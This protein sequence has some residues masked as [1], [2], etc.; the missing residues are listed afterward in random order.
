[1]VRDHRLERK[2]SPYRTSTEGLKD[3]P[4]LPE[5]P[6]TKRFT[7]KTEEKFQQY[8]NEGSVSKLKAA[9]KNLKMMRLKHTEA[10]KQM[11]EFHDEPARRSAISSLSKLEKR[12]PKPHHYTS[13]VLSDRQTRENSVMNSTNL[14]DNPF[15]ASTNRLPSKDRDSTMFGL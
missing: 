3:E 10:K 14:S 12:T 8:K 1:V 13:S 5:M 15:A 2:G 4:L 11:V 9:K 6:G 7:I